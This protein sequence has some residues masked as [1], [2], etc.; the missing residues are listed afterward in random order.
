MG[1]L[2]AVA[3]QQK[4][5]AAVEN[6]KIHASVDLGTANEK[7]GFAL[8]VKIKVEN[9]S[10]QALIQAAHEVSVPKVCLPNVYLISPVLPIQSCFDRRRE[11]RSRTTVRLAK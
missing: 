9:V 11:G 3:Q 7:S 5:T 8:A 10:D 1:A 2:R 6:A 4:K